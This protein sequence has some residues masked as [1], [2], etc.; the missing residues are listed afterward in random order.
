MMQPA[1]EIAPT[2]GCRRCDEIRMLMLPPGP[3]RRT[4]REFVPGTAPDPIE[5]FRLMAERGF[6]TRLVD[7]AAFPW[8]PFAGRHDLL[9]GLDP[10]RAL[11]VLMRERDCDL[12]LACNESPALPLLLA[13]SVC[14]FR[15]PIALVDP[16][17]TEAW[18]LRRRIL[19]LAIPRADAVITLGSTQVGYIRAHWQTDATVE[20]LHQHVDTSFYAPV[21]GETGTTILAVGDDVG[22][23]YPTLLQALAGVRAPV[24]LKTRFDGFDRARYP[25]IE[26]VT[27]RLPP[28][29]FREL[30]R[31][32][33]FV[34][35]PLVPIVTASGVSTVL[36]AMAM[37][38]ALI[39][40]DSPGIRDYVVPDETCL[41]VPCQ[42]PGALHV[43]IAELLNNPALCAY[44]GANG[45]RLVE[46][47]S[48]HTAYAEALCVALRR[49]VDDRRARLGG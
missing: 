19:D 38:K 37:G 39:V 15:A 43:A 44:L 11:R 17:L 1:I 23:D 7:P 28:M 46:Q 13:R 8:N 29:A 10:T 49:L 16:N 12:V 45:R 42:D 20:F 48:S 35:V 21:P 9:Q 18:P 41:V 4:W 30:Y 6:R 14:G 40:S 36:E 25:N 34:V 3:W 22:R 2:N 5:I 33:R 31:H 47:R 24:V 32:S 27:Q 26:I